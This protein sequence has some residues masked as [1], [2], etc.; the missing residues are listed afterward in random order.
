MASIR[1]LFYAIGAL[2]AIP[3][4]VGSPVAGDVIGLPNNLHF[5]GALPPFA[6]PTAHVQG[7][8]PIGAE[9]KMT[10]DSVQ[11]GSSC[12]PV[13]KTAT[14]TATETEICTETITDTATSTVTNWGWK[15]I[16][17]TTTAT[18]TDT[19]TSVVIDTTTATVTKTAT[20][21]VTDTTIS[22]VTDTATSTVT[23]CSGG[24]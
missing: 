18:K 21:T 20:S 1:H 22:T 2:S 19:T 3:G 16:T 24:W 13:T 9:M 14:S 12:T 10:P 8:G 5:T 7:I 15:T 6:E 23:S 17:D 11:W 4:V